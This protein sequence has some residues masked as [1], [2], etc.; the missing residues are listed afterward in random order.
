MRH[1][2]RTQGEHRPVVFGVGWDGDKL[3]TRV[4]KLI[5]V[6]IAGVALHPGRDWNSN[7]HYYYL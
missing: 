7:H 1:R 6:I 5:L 3:L 2:K 4:E